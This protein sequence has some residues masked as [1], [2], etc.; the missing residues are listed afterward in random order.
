MSHAMCSKLTNCITKNRKGAPIWKTIKE[1]ILWTLSQNA[2]TRKTSNSTMSIMTRIEFT[3]SRPTLLS[4]TIDE[5]ILWMKQTTAPQTSQCVARLFCARAPQ[6]IPR[7]PI[8]HLSHSHQPHLTPW[9]TAALQAKGISKNLLLP[10]KNHNQEKALFGHSHTVT[11]TW[12]QLWPCDRRGDA[13]VIWFVTCWYIVVYKYAPTMLRVING[14]TVTAVTMW[15][16]S[17]GNK[18]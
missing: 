9:N 16:Q 13:S 15:P 7:L 5:M 2:T 1:A 11:V 6:A 14:H 17:E 18:A 8:N 4:G 10:A 12:S 3:T